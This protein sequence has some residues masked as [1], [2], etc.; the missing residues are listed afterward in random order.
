M[1]EMISLTDIS[2]TKTTSKN[3]LSANSD[4]LELLLQDLLD[5]DTDSS[6]AQFDLKDITPKLDTNTQTV[7]DDMT[8]LLFTSSQFNQNDLKEVKNM[9]KSMF[10][11]NNTLLTQADIKE[12]KEI[13]N[14]K[15]L[16]SFADKKGLNIQKIKLQTQEGLKQARKNDKSDKSKNNTNALLSKDVVEMKSHKQLNTKNTAHQDSKNSNQKSLLSNI[17]QK[18]K[19]TTNTK[20][21]ANTKQ[22]T[23][24]ITSNQTASNMQAHTQTT[25]KINTRNTAPEIQTMQHTQTTKQIH[26]HTT[27]D[28]SHHTKTTTK[29]PT[30]QTIKTNT[31]NTQSLQTNQSINQPT[32]QT[33]NHTTN[34]QPKQTINHTTNPQPKQTATTN[35]THKSI[36]LENLIQKTTQDVTTAK[37]HEE[38]KDT[39]THHTTNTASRNDA[40]INQNQ[41]MQ[42]NQIK[43]RS[44]QAKETIRHFSQNLD[45][46][47]KNYKPPISKV[48]I[49]LN[50]KNL[51][52]VEV[53]I[54][55]RG[56]NIQINMNTDQNNI[57]MFQTH[58]AEFRQAL[59]N[60]GFS[61]IDMNFNS[62]QDKER[63]Q[64]QAKKTYQE[65]EIDENG[66]IE[67]L[68]D[69][70][71]A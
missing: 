25:N 55:Q 7:K 64:N 63:K 42:V 40:V 54:I 24:D 38:L 10:D 39:T 49:E 46:A 16:I 28:N 58:Q 37:P 36:T 6:L 56:N 27:N 52:K 1:I 22:T 18:D 20:Q 70:K 2:T 26:Q 11:Q 61:N 5:E 69:Y 59:A 45:D 53:S 44:V 65:N 57:Q 29:T 4:F 50:P 32:K 9:I 13:T 47:I 66:E 34:P 12:L 19:Q 60:I 33:I 51:G 31:Q 68:A 17:L 23:T 3:S 67:I 21:T 48:D 43:A 35:R 30:T 41:T 8:A 62:N 15:D 14:L 71:Y